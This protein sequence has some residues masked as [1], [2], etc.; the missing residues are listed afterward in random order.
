M[1]KYEEKVL[2]RLEEIGAWAKEGWREKE[3]ADE[4]KISYSGF[5]N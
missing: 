4:L 3:I 2:P 1:G 5:R